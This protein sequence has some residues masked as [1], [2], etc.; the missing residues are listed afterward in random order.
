MK[1]QKALLPSFELDNALVSGFNDWVKEVAE[2]LT[3]EGM[4]STAGCVEV[5]PSNIEEL[6]LKEYESVSIELFEKKDKYLQTLLKISN[7]DAF[8]LLGVKINKE[9]FSKF[10]FDLCSTWCEF[11]DVELF[12]YFLI[13]LY[14]QISEG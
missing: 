10:M 3:Y 2:C 4:V 5:T 6:L 12:S 14:I 13:G 8:K 1:L 7:H 9:V 11:L